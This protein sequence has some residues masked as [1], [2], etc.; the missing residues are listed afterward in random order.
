MN[1]FEIL[2]VLINYYWDYES[3]FGINLLKK[4]IEIYDRKKGKNIV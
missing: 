1:P 2:D 3:G 4:Y